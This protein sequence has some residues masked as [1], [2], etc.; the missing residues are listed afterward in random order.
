MYGNKDINCLLEDLQLLAI[1]NVECDI[2]DKSEFWTNIRNNA[3]VPLGLLHEP[4][5]CIIDGIKITDSVGEI[6]R[7]KTSHKKLKSFLYNR[8]ILHG[9]KFDLIYRKL[10]EHTT[11]RVP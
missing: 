1:I 9:N 6:T 10:F 7:K 5:V 3:T 4:T 2:R 8:G 11:T